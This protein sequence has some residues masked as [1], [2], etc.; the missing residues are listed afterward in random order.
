MSQ[1]QMEYSGYTM[2][3]ETQ[4]LMNKIALE[5]NQ[6]I[7]RMKMASMEGANSSERVSGFPAPELYN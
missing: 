6:E 5:H 2:D 4:A 7:Y 3:D 1:Q